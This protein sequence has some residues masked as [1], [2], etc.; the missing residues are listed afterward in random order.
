[1]IDNFIGFYR[2]HYHEPNFKRIIQKKEID[3]GNVFIFYFL[4]KLLATKC[5]KFIDSELS[6]KDCGFEEV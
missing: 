4:E 6:A 3:W 2:S 5:N 1:M